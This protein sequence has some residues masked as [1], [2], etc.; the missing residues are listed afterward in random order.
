MILGV[1]KTAVPYDCDTVHLQGGDVVV[2]FTDG[3]SEAMN[4]EGNEYGEERLETVIRGCT[5]CGAQELTDAI[6]RDIVEYAGGAPQ[7][8]DITMMVLRVTT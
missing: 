2:L 1:L 3:V 5:G 4:R 8:D 6:H 7:S